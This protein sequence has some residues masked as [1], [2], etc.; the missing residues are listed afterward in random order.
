MKKILFVLVLI[1]IAFCIWLFLHQPAQTAEQ[2]AVPQAPEPTNTTSAPPMT[3]ALSQ[4]MPPTNAFVR[5]DSIDEATWN[6]IMINRQVI[7]SENQPIEFYARIVD[8]DGQ[9]IKGAK[10]EL[11]VSRMDE[12]MFAPTNYFHWD[13]AKAVQDIPFELLSDANGWVCLTNKTGQLIQ[14]NDLSKAGYSFKMPQIGSFGY[15][16]EGKHL[17][18]DTGMEDAFNPEKG[19]VFHLQRIVK[20][21]VP[22]ISTSQAGQ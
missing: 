16:P 8:Q 1:I 11:K 21:S 6:R 10:L 15:E 9:A 12:T 4:A 17:I 5:P 13:P 22:S 3:N 20:G 2:N 19:Y 18:G 7:L 14:I